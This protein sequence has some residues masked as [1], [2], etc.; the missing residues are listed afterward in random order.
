MKIMNVVYVLWDKLYI[1]RK[2]KNQDVPQS[3]LMAE[4]ARSIVEMHVKH[5]RPIAPDEKKYFELSH[6]VHQDLW[7]TEWSDIG[8]L[9]GK[10][11]EYYKEHFS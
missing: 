11:V 1:Y 5:G 9:Y 10:L 2:A 4:V 3:L 6:Q 7:G 8:V